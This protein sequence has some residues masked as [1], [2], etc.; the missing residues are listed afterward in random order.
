MLRAALLALLA[1][2]APAWASASFPGAV[3]AHLS[4]AAPPPC[5]LCHFNGITG[6]GTVTTP[7]GV[8]L[9]ARGAVVGSEPALLVALEALRTAGTDSDGDGVPDIQEL[10][11]GTDPNL[12]GG[13]D[14]GT[15]LV[16]P[17]L[18]YGCGAEVAP[19]LLGG[20]G[21]LLLAGRRRRRSA[22]TPSP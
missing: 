4:L 12:A 22:T 14:G 11:A 3:Q 16:V 6:A 2:A 8:S 1:V 10:I 21:V 18:R 15:G 19:G 20:L 17:P 5:A 13:A 9:R 7:F